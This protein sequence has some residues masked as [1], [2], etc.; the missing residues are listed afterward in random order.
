MAQNKGQQGQ[1]QNIP[2]GLRFEEL[3]TIGALDSSNIFQARVKC[4]VLKGN[5]I[6]AC[7]EMFYQ[8]E[9]QSSAQAKSVKT[10]DA[11]FLNFSFSEPAEASAKKVVLEIFSKTEAGMGRTSIDI[12]PIP[13]PAQQTSAPSQVPAGQ[14]AAP[15]QQATTQQA[16]AQA[17]KTV[18]CK[19]PCCNIQ[20]PEGTKICPTCKW[21]Q[22]N[23]D[24]P[25]HPATPYIIGM[26]V[27]IGGTALRY[28]AHGKDGFSPLYWILVGVAAMFMIAW[29]LSTPT[30]RR[31][32]RNF[33]FAMGI[34]F[35]LL[36][37][38]VPGGTG[39]VPSKTDVQQQPAGKRL[40]I[41]LEPNE[42]YTIDEVSAGE[43]WR[44]ASFNGSFSHRVDVGDGKACWKEVNNNL[45]WN[46]DVSGALQVKA[47]NTPVTLTIDLA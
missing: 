45:P 46:A 25:P 44:Y 18:K 19:N 15:Q 7:Q 21:D 10:D 20:L 30:T 32:V 11:G 13:A 42:I 2:S 31:M 38:V 43:N 29:L 37:L 35:T 12:P 24:A 40:T 39:Q 47:G 9:F 6:H 41:T 28:L 33:A 23:N 27:F 17:A 8:T 34:G 22:V 1:K 14:Q 3:K 16:P 4:R 5:S 26:A 36:A